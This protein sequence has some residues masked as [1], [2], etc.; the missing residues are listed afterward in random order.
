[1]N[2]CLVKF[3]SKAKTDVLQ[4]FTLVKISSKF[5]F[6]QAITI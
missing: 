5:H 1:M 6:M 4:D 3:S 2:F